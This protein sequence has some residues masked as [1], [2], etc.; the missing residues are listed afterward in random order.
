MR[1]RFCRSFSGSTSSVVFMGRNV[2]RYFVFGGSTT[3]DFIS[4]QRQTWGE[5]LEELL[6]PERYAVINHGGV[7][8]STA[9]NLVQTAFYESSFGAKPR[10]AIYY[11]GW[12]DL[13]SIHVDKLD[14]GYADFQTR[15]LVDSLDARRAAGPRLSVSPLLSLIGRLAW[16]VIDS[17]RPLAE[18]RLRGARANRP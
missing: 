5:R 16:L 2:M 18:A 17:V 4:P 15:S 14:P 13:R 3:F 12:N 6:D 7:G 9:Q 11:V 10:C 1:F 8:Y